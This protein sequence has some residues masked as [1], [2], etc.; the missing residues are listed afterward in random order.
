MNDNRDVLVWLI[1]GGCV[2]ALTLY[3]VWY[4]IQ[5]L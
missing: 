3:A 5:I 4:L 2:G 1:V